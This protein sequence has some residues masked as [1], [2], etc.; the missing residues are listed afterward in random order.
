[1][2]RLIPCALGALALGW[3]AAALSDELVIGVRTEPQSI[4]PHWNSL[5]GDKQVEQHYF[6]R[7]VHMNE[8]SQPTPQLAVSVEPI[9]DDTW[10]LKLRQGV[11]W[12]DGADFDADDV[13][14][15]YKRLID[16]VPGAPSAPF[17]AIGRGNKQ[18]KKVDAYTVH[19]T[20]DGP[21]PTLRPDMGGF[22]ILAEH[23]AKGAEPSVDFNSGKAAIGTGPYKFVEF[24]SGDRTVIEKNPNYWGD[25]KTWA[26]KWDKI[27]FKPITEGSSRLAAVL[28]GDVDVVDYL[29]T[30]DIARLKKDG[31]IVVAEGSSDRVIYFRM[32]RRD[33]EPYVTTNDDKPM[34]PNPLLDWRVRRAMSLAIN[35]DAIRDRVMGGA[36][37]PT[38]NVVP[39]GFFGHH[40]GIEPDPYDPEE[41]KKLLASAGYPDGFKITLHGPNDRYINDAKIAETVAQMWT[42]VGIKTAVS[43]R[44]RNIFFTKQRSGGPNSQPYFQM[45]SYSVTLVGWGTG[46]GEALYSLDGLVRTYNDMAGHGYSNSGRYSNLRVDVLIA[47]AEKELDDEKRL[48]HLREATEIALRDYAVIPI[49]FQVNFWGLRKGLK[50]TPQT[51]ERTYGWNIHKAG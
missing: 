41:S 49:H 10:E 28:A 8:F 33:V 13:I 40:E 1:M 7:L 38:G 37:I 24:K 9:A 11:K 48:V 39:K 21:Y 51:N 32:H 45:P 50:M 25:A 15:T 36:S 30:A 4:D 3:S 19:V 31:K 44:P 5:S 35:R 34:F 18:F 47:M 16:K 29:P 22:A 42:R 17:H 12:H 43:T 26:P 23:A 14:F 2:K 20:T 46:T 27:T 6:Q